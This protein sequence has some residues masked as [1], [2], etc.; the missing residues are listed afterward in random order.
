MIAL[1]IIF[2]DPSSDEADAALAKA[3]GPD[4]VLAAD[5]VATAMDQ[6]T[7]VTRVNPIDP[8]LDAGATPGV[9][10]VDLDGDAYLRRMPAIAGQLRARGPAPGRNAGETAAARCADPVFR[11]AA[12]RIRRSPTTRRSIRSSFC[13][14]DG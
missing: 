8:L 4:V 11:A 5:D 2:A 1:D 7:Q 12:L 9:T 10:S 3:M 13:R 14:R 6:A